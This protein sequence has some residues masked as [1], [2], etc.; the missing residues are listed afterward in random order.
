[1]RLATSLLLAS[2]LLFAGPQDDLELPTVQHAVPDEP[3]PDRWRPV[4]NIRF[5]G[6]IRIKHEIFYSRQTHDGRA[7]PF[8]H[9][10]QWLAV[11]A[12]KMETDFADPESRTGLKIPDEPLLIRADRSTPF[13]HIQKV[14]E[15]CG[16]R[17]VFIWKI[18]LACRM[19]DGDDG[20][21]TAYLPKDVRE[22][23]GPAEEAERVEVRIRVRQPGTKLEP[24]EGKKPVT[25][26]SNRFVYGDDR[27]LEYAVGP[28]ETADPAALEQRLTKIHQARSSAEGPTVPILVDARPGTTYE[29]VTEALDAIL[30]AGFADVLFARADDEGE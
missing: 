16:E 2:S 9:V 8:E 17:G 29:D 7:D 25:S 20:R 3:P 14:M 5:D 30:A 15:L 11:A 13:E 1:M 22:F 19:P 4:V 18:Q 23:L 21:L 26:D 10:R 27:E 6:S 24:G 28:F 12:S